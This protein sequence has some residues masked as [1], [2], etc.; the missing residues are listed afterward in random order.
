[1]NRHHWVAFFDI[2]NGWRRGSKCAACGLAVYGW[3]G[4]VGLCEAA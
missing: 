1:M 3:G 2:R 4:F